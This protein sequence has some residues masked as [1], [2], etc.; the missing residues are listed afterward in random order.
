MLT[1]P[2]TPR[3]ICRFLLY[4]NKFHIPFPLS[5]SSEIQT[6]ASTYGDLLCSPH[7]MTKHVSQSSPWSSSDTATW[8]SHLTFNGNSVYWGTLVLDLESCFPS[9]HPTSACSLT[10]TAVNSL[11]L[12]LYHL[13]SSAAL[14]Q[15]SS[16]AA[17][18]C[19]FVSLPPDSCLF[20]LSCTQPS[21]KFLTYR[22]SHVTPWYKSFRWLTVTYSMHSRLLH[23]ADMTFHVFLFQ[24]WNVCRSNPK[25]PII[26]LLWTRPSFKFMLLFTCSFCLNTTPCLEMSIPCLEISF[27]NL[28]TLV[29][30]PTAIPCSSLYLET[31]WACLSHCIF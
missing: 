10:Y 8:V 20:S 14:I 23:L 13:G 17:A 16:E 25:L 4:A 2:R 27:A 29:Y 22:V 6:Y 24:F 19:L 1:V 12:A 9:T 7:S 11:M 31:T 18:E 21:G 5:N 15:G 26:S 28:G 3:T 30:I